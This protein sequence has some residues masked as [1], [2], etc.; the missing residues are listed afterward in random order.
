M[1]DGAAGDTT[2]C[3]AV[4]A[5]ATVAAVAVLAWLL[6]DLATDPRALDARGP[7]GPRFDD[8]LVWACSAATVAGTCWLWAVTT[9]VALGAARGRT[10]PSAPAVPAGLRRAVLA[11]CGVALAGG[12]A[13]PAVA[14]PGQVHHDH[15]RPATAALV[16]GLPLPDRATAPSRAPAP[17]PAHSLVVRRGDTLWALARRD[18]GPRA[19]DGAV[20]RRWQ[21]IYA[22][23]R[24]VVGANPD[25]IHPG[26]QLRLPRD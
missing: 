16:S 14:S 25:V 11:A 17:A 13:S 2:R 8:L 5:A 15:P 7:A 26:Q 12:L 6:P 18:L 24:G 21:A 1:S 20:N 10:G 19:A 9:L 4:C 22:L 23:N 3:L